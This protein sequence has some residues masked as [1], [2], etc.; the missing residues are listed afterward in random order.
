MP[1]TTWWQCLERKCS[2]YSIWFDW[3]TGGIHVETVYPSM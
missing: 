1:T 3:S 2:I